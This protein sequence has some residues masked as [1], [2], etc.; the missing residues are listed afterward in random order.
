MLKT[1]GEKYSSN[2]K[3]KPFTSTAFTKPETM[4]M[5]M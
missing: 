2:L 4:N 3:E 1:S 5:T